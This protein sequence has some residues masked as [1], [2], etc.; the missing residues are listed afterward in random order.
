NTQMSS[1]DKG[2]DLSPEKLDLRISNCSPEPS[3]S[4]GSVDS[5]H[6]LTQSSKIQSD[7]RVSENDDSSSHGM[8]FGDSEDISDTQDGRVDKVIMAV[9]LRNRKLGCAYY[10][11]ATSKLYLMEDV[12]ESPPY[13]MVNLCELVC[14]LI[15]RKLG[16]D[17]LIKIS[18]KL[19][20]FQV[21]P[22]IILVSSRADDA[23]IQ[24]LQA[25][26]G[27]T[28]I[29][30]IVEIRPGS[31]FIY[32]SAKTK[33]FSIRLGD[34]GHVPSHAEASKQEIYL[35]LS[36]IVNLESIETVCC[37]GALINYISRAKITGAL[38]EDLQVGVLS[39]EQFSL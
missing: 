9:N 32:A 38:S 5:L 21:S 7:P 29:P 6:P 36:S 20:R 35:H 16:V 19:V 28:L 8:T 27:S 3:R 17:I 39:I 37:A 24:A 12:A 4:T 10:N 23:F 22:S 26:D 11:V 31:E 18:S 14:L 2:D 1:N 33:L 30:Y 13:D 25:E 15:K 34:Q